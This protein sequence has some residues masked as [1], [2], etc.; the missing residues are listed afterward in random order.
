M[1]FIWN[2]LIIAVIEENCIPDIDGGN[3]KVE[4]KFMDF[5]R[6]QK[7]SFYN[8]KIEALDSTLI[9]IHVLIKIHLLKAL[10]KPCLGSHWNMDYEKVISPVSD[11]L[12]FYK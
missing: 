2:S 1:G 8:L 5:A 3:C 7:T 10:G 11:S 12:I 9:Y 6:F 4:G